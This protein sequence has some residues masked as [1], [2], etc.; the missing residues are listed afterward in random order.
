MEEKGGHE[1]GKDNR[2]GKRSL[3]LE[4]ML[5]HLQRLYKFIGKERMVMSTSRILQ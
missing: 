2:D 1:S 5:K 4:N 3:E